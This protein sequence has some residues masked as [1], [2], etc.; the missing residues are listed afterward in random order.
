LVWAAVAALVAGILA[1]AMHLCAGTAAP[2]VFAGGWISIGGYVLLMAIWKALGW[3]GICNT[4]DCEAAAI[5][6]LALSVL[7]AVLF[8]LS[9]L[10]ICFW[11]PAWYVQAGFVAF[12]GPILANCQLK[13]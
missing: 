7:G 6:M 12:W 2:T 4:D 5:T 10:F 1:L 8:I 9:S 11:K 13:K 3:L